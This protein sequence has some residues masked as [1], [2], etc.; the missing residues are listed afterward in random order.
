M[1]MGIYFRRVAL[2]YDLTGAVPLAIPFKP[3]I[4]YVFAVF[5]DNSSLNKAIRD[6]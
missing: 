4:A 2:T 1:K 5:H 6:L 3:L